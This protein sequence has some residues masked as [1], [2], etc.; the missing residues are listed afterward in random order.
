MAVSTHDGLLILSPFGAGMT[1]CI[2]VGR[3]DEA[4]GLIEVMRDAGLRPDIR[5]YNIILTGYS[6][7]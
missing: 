6:R 5:A 2:G 7:Y 1:A 4:E 3:L